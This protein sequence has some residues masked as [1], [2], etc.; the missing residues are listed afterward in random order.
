MQE[1]IYTLKERRQNEKLPAPVIGKGR[2][3][4][5][6]LSDSDGTRIEFTETFLSK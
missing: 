3:W 4:L 6:N 2:R 5:L 1:I